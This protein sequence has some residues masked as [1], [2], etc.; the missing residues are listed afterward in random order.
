MEKIKKYW[1]DGPHFKFVDS[2]KEVFDAVREVTN[3]AIKYEFNSHANME[4]WPHVAKLCIS[5]DKAE[6]GRYYVSSS[7][8]IEGD[9]DN[10]QETEK[11]RRIENAE[12]N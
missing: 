12:Y 5:V 4:N 7:F 11:T 9:I 8:E 1:V 3:A 6:D 2:K 10:F